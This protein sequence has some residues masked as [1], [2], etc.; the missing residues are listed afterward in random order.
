MGVSPNDGRQEQTEAQSRRAVKDEIIVAAL[1]AGRSYREAGDKAGVDKRTV[2]RRMAQPDYAERVRHRRSEFV[3]ATDGRLAREGPNAADTIAACLDDPDPRVR[4]SAARLL[5]RL[6]ITCPELVLRS[7]LHFRGH[8]FF[9][10]RKIVPPTLYEWLQEAVK[11]LIA[12]QWEF[13]ALGVGERTVTSHAARYRTAKP[14]GHGGSR[15]DSL[16]RA[17]TNG[18]FRLRRRILFP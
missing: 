8:R 18:T 3:A 13:A 17:L 15:V 6:G 9:K 7:V 1:A 12:E 2:A 5:L 16:P 4:L 11:Q 10:N 14:S